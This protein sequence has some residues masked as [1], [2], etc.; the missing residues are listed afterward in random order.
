MKRAFT[1]V[2]LLVVI[3]VIAVL[4]AMLLPALARARGQARRVEC[5]SRLH[6]WSTAFIL[7]THDN[8][9]DIPREGYYL[10]GRTHKHTWE[11]VF[12]QQSADAWFNALP[13]SSVNCRPAAH[14]A[15]PVDRRLDFYRRDSFFHCPSAPFPRETKSE[16]DLTA[17]FSLA[18]NSQLIEYPNVPTIKFGRIR[19]KAR[20][21]LFLDNL[22]DE[23]KPVVDDQAH[24][25]LGQPA[26]YAPRFAGRRH[27]NGG[28][29][30]FADG[31][32]QTL[33]GEDVVETQGRN[34]GYDIFP[35][36]KVKWWPD[37]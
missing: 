15:K 23:E 19:D 7:Y 11:Q 1:L 33:K 34:R 29:L 18:M 14:Y 10:D 3:A 26:A 12:N 28:N 24:T 6:Q 27:G 17:T 16:F 4:A 35:P 20:T 37:D 22:L 8:S 21:V 36:E 25:D 30:A 31:H 5:I 32:A 2:E 9:D 13:R